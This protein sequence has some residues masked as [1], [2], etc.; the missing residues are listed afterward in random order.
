[1]VLLLFSVSY[2][3]LNFHQFHLVQ[4]NEMFTLADFVEFCKYE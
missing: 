1:M 4:W 2:V 3:F